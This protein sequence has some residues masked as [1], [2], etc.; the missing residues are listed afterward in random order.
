M[1]YSSQ[2]ISR[3]RASRRLDFGKLRTPTVHAESL[4]FLDVL[5]TPETRQEVHS[6]HAK[7]RLLAPPYD[8][9]EETPMKADKG[10]AQEPCCLGTVLEEEARAAGRAAKE[11]AKALGKRLRKARTFISDHCP[12]GCHGL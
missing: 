3:N 9:Y 4:I 12:S 5:K 10:I 1:G 7:R 6:F 8:P 11:E 2:K